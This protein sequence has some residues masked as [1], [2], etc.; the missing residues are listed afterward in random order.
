MMRALPAFTF[1]VAVWSSVAMGQD[2]PLSAIDWLSDSVRMAPET[3]GPIGPQTATS[4][5]AP[6]VAVTSL[7]APSPN[8]VGILS[9]TLTDLPSSLWARSNEDD[10]ITLISNM[11]AP[12]LPV[13]NDVLTTLLLAQADAP[14][15]ST[16]EGRF[17]LARVDSLLSLGK[18]QEAEALLQAATPETP[19]HFQ[20]YFDVTLLLGTE[21]DACRVMDQRPDVAPTYPARIFCLARSGDWAAA[22][23]TLNTRR[24]LGDISDE[25]DILISLFLDPEVFELNAEL[26]PPTRVTPLVFRMREAIGETLSTQDLPLAFAHADLR[27]TSGWKAQLDAAE[28][29]AR[30]NALDPNLLQGLYTSKRASASGGVWDRVAAF[31]ELDAALRGGNSRKVSRALL[32]V[33]DGM[34]AIRAETTF[35]A[36]VGNRLADQRLR[37]P[38]AAVAEEIALLAGHTPPARSMSNPYLAALGQ[39][40]P[41]EVMASDPMAIAIQAAFNGARGDEGLATV[42]EEGRLGEAILSALVMAEDGLDGDLDALTK[43]IVFF[44]E[45][46]FENVARQIGLQVL[47]LD[48]EI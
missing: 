15:G 48:T 46:G 23:L 24:A 21:D 7:D 34:Q 31:Q 33:W 8:A 2:Q 3:A 9:P 29:L 26:P 19:E 38:A 47:I 25:D 32:V 10:L 20:R 18:L 37:G 28:R 22:A 13:L 14:L 11:S 45:A 16:A 35:A 12:S 30:H 17:F 27:D 5:T 39:G 4:A 43:V 1:A 41:Q 40:R 42:L 36:L 44:R 6:S